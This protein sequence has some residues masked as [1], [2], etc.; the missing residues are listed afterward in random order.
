MSIS[1]SLSATSS[2]GSDGCW[3][4]VWNKQDNTN[5]G[6]R[7][8]WL[9]SSIAVSVSI[10]DSNTRGGG[11]KNENQIKMKLQVKCWEEKSKLGLKPAYIWTLKLSNHTHGYSST[12][13]LSANE[14]M[15]KNSVHVHVYTVA[16]I[17]SIDDESTGN[18]L[19][20]KRELK[21]KLACIMHIKCKQSHRHTHRGL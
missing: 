9:A 17:K 20:R 14:N 6:I 19:R 11:R 18:V 10:S 1:F 13:S 15:V 5:R 8:L 4:S 12:C 2:E 16:I 3:S 21:L 7:W